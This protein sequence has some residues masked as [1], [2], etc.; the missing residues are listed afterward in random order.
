MKL[1]QSSLKGKNVN[2]NFN[3]S[4]IEKDIQ[5]LMT[6]RSTKKTYMPWNF[7]KNFKPTLLWLD[8][9]MFKRP[10]TVHHFPT[11]S[12]LISQLTTPDMSCNS[13]SVFNYPSYAQSPYFLCSFN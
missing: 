3:T 10:M 8:K 6:H 11:T 13:T 2:I 1:N 12:Y 9:Q 5:V 7:F 4:Y